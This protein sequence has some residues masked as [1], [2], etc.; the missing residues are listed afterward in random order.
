MGCWNC[1]GLWPCWEGE[2]CH[3]SFLE[4]FLGSCK[5]LF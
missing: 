5:E 4:D 3:C 1:G 2:G